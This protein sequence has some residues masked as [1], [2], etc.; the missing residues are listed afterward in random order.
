MARAGAGPF[1]NIKCLHC[2]HNF[3]M[4]GQVADNY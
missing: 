1:I 2:H 3:N 4:N